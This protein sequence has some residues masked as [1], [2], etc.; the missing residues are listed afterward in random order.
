MATPNGANFAN[1]DATFGSPLAATATLST[2]GK[3]KISN[4]ITLVQ[5]KTEPVYAPKL[6]E[7]V[8]KASQA[9]R[10]VKNY[11]MGAMAIGLIPL[12]LVDM[13]AVTAIQIKTI[14]S[15][16]KQYE[17]PFSQ[18]QVKS[19]LMSLL[20]GTITL[21]TTVLAKSLPVI[22]Q[23]TG[24]I[25]AMIVGGATTYAIG[26]IF[27]EHFESGGNFLDFDPETMRTHFQELYE[28]GKQLAVQSTKR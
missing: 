27:I 21:T 6:I 2:Q 17:V 24:I 4:P 19:L 15:I 8:N 28:D 20:G 11:M 16:A 13:V 18:N 9:H 25:S 7:R 3:P 1:K 10:T 14:H 23:A 12:P 26:K 5:E 22:G